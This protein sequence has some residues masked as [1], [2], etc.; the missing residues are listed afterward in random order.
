[1][2]LPPPGPEGELDLG[3]ALEFAHQLAHEAGRVAL[4]A[5]RT[6][7][8]V[9]LKGDDSPVTRVDRE[10]EALLRLRLALRYPS[11]GIRGE[12]QEP[13]QPDARYQW[14]VD[15]I[16]G[17]RSFLTGNPLFGTLIALADRGR[18]VL[19]LIDHPA[20]G[21]R[22]SAAR[23]LPTRSQDRPARTRPCAGLAQARLGTTS[24]YLVPS[25]LRPSFERLAAAVLDVHLGGDCYLYGSLASGRLDL[26]CEAGL[27]PHD[28]CALVPVVEGAGGVISDWR[29][30]PLTLDSAGDVLAAG[31]ARAHGAAL[32]LLGG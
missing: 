24:P 29:G 22:W 1:M 18:P 27:A 28:F 19:G 20:L 5:F 2:D 30:R 21:E 11:H 15:P 32:E 31:D 8:E 6:P 14:L 13:E 16:D 7:L 12:E 4:H 25:N 17:T 26:V 23:G 10:I 3:L 9:E